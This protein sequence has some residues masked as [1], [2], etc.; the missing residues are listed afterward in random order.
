MVGAASALG[1][2]VTCPNQGQK[3]SET[4][5]NVEKNMPRSPMLFP[6]DSPEGSGHRQLADREGSGGTHQGSEARAV[7]SGLDAKQVEDL[8]K[9]HGTNDLTSTP[10]EN[11]L[12]VHC[13]TQYYLILTQPVTTTRASSWFHGERR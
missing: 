3:H 8:R 9:L 5:V 7:A 6:R 4:P 2:F 13:I 12:H 1:T 11:S 10:I